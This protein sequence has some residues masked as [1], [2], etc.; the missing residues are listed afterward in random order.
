[1]I[2]VVADPSHPSH[3]AASMPDTTTTAAFVSD[4]N[5]ALQACMTV[6]L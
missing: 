2:E 1:V 6:S 3:D 5:T 4:P